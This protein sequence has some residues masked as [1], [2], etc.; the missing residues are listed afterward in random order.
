MILFFAEFFERF[1]GRPK[2]L[3]LE[4]L[5]EVILFDFLYHLT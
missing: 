5:L 3:R 2:S 4:F 1:A